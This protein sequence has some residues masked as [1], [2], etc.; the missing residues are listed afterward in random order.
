MP[1][2][3]VKE[4]VPIF[5]VKELVFVQSPSSQGWE[6]W[7]GD[8][9]GGRW[10]RAD[11]FPMA[12]PAQLPRPLVPAQLK[13]SSFRVI[14]AHLLKIMLGLGWCHFLWSPE[15]VVLWKSSTTIVCKWSAFS[16]K[17]ELTPRCKEEMFQNVGILWEPRCWNLLHWEGSG[18]SP[19]C[20]MPVCKHFTQGWKSRQMY[21]ALGVALPNTTD[22][23]FQKKKKKKKREMKI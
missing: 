5:K 18:G 2:V 1:I 23:G 16:H 7:E 6:K 19:Y 21:D 11:G 22:Q 4:G 10:K 3:V 15:W 9:S 13:T 8:N 17:E 14:V 12:R 20:V